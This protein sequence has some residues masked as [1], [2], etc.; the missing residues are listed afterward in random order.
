[1]NLQLENRLQSKQISPT[2]MRLLVLEYF[3]QHN[4]AHSLSDLENAFMHSDRTTLYRTL[5][6][7]EDKGLVHAIQ[8][9]TGVTKY[10][11]CQDDCSEGAHR[12]LHLHFF[13]TQCKETYCLPKTHIPEIQLPNGFI[14]EEF[15]L[16]GKGICKKCYTASL[17]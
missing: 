16:T 7:F 10:A 13:C 2:A 17:Q 3:L 4:M 14:A 8:D 9:G 6:T 5:K 11:I 1:M 12:D 15:N